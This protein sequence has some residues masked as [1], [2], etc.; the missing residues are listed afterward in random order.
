MNGMS[1]QPSLL[2][3]ITNRA[4]VKNPTEKQKKISSVSYSK[5]LRR[6]NQVNP[7]INRQRPSFPH[8]STAESLFST[9]ANITVDQAALNYR[10]FQTNNYPG[11]MESYPIPTPLMIT[12]SQ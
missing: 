4:L 5:R 10:S 8:Q 7:S 11:L 9:S 6:I 12:H 3:P 2:V 1:K